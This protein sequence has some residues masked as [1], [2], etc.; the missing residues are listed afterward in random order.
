[1]CFYGIQLQVGYKIT[2]IKTLRRFEHHSARVNTCAFNRDATLIASG[3]Y[4]SKICLWDCRAAFRKPI[5]VLQ[6]AKDSVE[7]LE[8]NGVEILSGYI[9]IF[10]L[11]LLMDS[12]GFTM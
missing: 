9:F 6:D 10:K 3:G 11:D 1:M 7:S 4:D 8:I 5:Q 2:K 12:F